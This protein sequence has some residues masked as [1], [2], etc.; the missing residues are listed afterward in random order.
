MDDFVSVFVDGACRNNGQED[1]QGGCGVYW[2]DENPLNVIEYLIGEK[3]TNNRAEL[4]AAIIAL[5]QAKHNQTKKVQIST[6]S[7]YVKDGI[8]KWIHGWKANGWKTTQKSD[9]LNKDLW[10]TLDE[11]SN[12]LQLKCCWVEGHG[13]V[14]GNLR[15]DGLAKAGISSESCHWQEVVKSTEE[16]NCCEAKSTR[17]P[18]KSE[19]RQAKE[20]RNSDK[21]LEKKYECGICE[22]PVADDG[23]QCGDC[24]LWFHYICSKLPPYIPVVHV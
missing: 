9:F 4:T 20:T 11:I 8:T 3:Q 14:I 1:P 23:I 2:S 5:A 16:E 15:A 22:S 13:E 6:D 18:R 10:T 19:P 7:K 24:K 17:E 21:I 12:Q